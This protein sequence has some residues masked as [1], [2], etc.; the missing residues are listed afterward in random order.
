MKLRSLVLLA[1]TLAGSPLAF[2]QSSTQPT[3]G[4]S[5]ALL[6]TQQVVTGDAVF[7]GRA[8]ATA[9]TNALRD[10]RGNVGVNIAAGALNAQSN[11]LALVSATDTVVRTRQ[12]V[13]AMANLTGGTSASLGTNALAGASGN[14]A[15]NVAAGVANAQS[16]SLAIH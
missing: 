15:V 12:D 11:Q 2:A 13:Q 3:V 7:G 10:A 6:A 8:V 1:A 5:I 16:N 14:I 4:Q 9:G